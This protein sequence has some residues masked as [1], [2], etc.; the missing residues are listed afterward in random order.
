MSPQ[1]L[2]HALVH[3]SFAYENGQVP[4][5]ERL[6]FLGDA[7]LQ[8][9]VTEELYRRHPEADEGLLSRMRIAVVSRPAL[10]LVAR[11]LGVG[12]AML[13]GRGEE[14]TGGRDRD[15]LLADTVEALIGVVHVERGPEAS[16][17]LVLRI[18]APLLDAAPGE[19]VDHDH[20]TVLQVLAAERGLLPPVYELTRT[21]PAHD[22]EFS[23]VVVLAAAEHGTADVDGDAARVEGRGTG[24]SKKL[25]E[26]AAAA[27]VVQ[28]L[29]AAAG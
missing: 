13:L 9:A 10:A 28:A 23:A 17:D 14:M 4:T 7:V 22:P 8:L 21:G 29:R 16:R 6:E 24:R 1:G 27:A 18:T 25:A 5:N 11:A 20:K 3:R 19:G 26:Q 12:P 15:S 2:T